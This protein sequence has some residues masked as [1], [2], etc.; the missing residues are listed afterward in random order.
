MLRDADRR[1]FDF[2]CRSLVAGQWILSNAARGALIIR[3]S[4]LDDS[5]PGLQ[6]LKIKYRESS[7]NGICLVEDKR[8][9]PGK[10]QPGTGDYS[11]ISLMRFWA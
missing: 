10:Q 8:P 6:L 4:I 9:E 3:C 7:R 11:A 2:G 1:E 5:L